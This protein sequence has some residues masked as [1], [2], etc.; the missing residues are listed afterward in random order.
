MA[1]P[2]TLNELFFTAIDRFRRNPVA[3]RVKRGG[4]W[5]SLS[6]DELLERVQALSLGLGEL[7]VRAGDRV[8]LLSE[9]RPEWAIADYACLTAR[10][11]DVPVYPTLPPKQIEYIL[12]DSGAVAL[13]VS[14]REQL[15]K[16]L[17][18]RANL[19]ALRHVIAFDER[20]E[21]E[22]VLPLEAVYA[23]GRAVPELAPAW[24]EA[25]LREA[26]DDLAT[27]IYTSGTTGEPKGVMLTHGNITTNVV[28]SL[29]VLALREGDECL[30]FLPLSHI[31]ERMAGHYLML[32][33]GTVISYASS[34]DAVS[35]EMQE[36][37]PTV[38]LSVPRLFEKIYARVLETAL[39]GS[40][41]KRS[42]FFWAKRVGEEWVEYRLT[43][44]QV[45][46]LLDM[47]YW[48]ARRLV[49]RKLHARVGS[50]LRFFVS[51]GAPLSADIARFFYAAG[52]PILEG[53]GLTETSPVIAVNRPERTR[54]G[55]VGPLISGV[56]VKIAPDGEILTRGPHVMKGYYRKPEATA[57]VIDAE[58]WFHT[59]DIGEL[60]ADGFLRI[61]DRKKD[62]IVTAGGKNIAPQP[63]E[64][65]AKMNKYVAN[66][67]MIGDKRRFP[68]ML[69]VPNFEKLVAWA[70]HRGL[71]FT[72]MAA[73][74]ALPETRA[75]IEREMQKAL[76]GLAHFEM[77]KKFLLLPRDFT[78]EA[79]ELTPKLSVRR[80]Q[81]E[82]NFA[83]EIEGL[84]EESVVEGAAAGV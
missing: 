52:L 75:K 45:P 74:V 82:K 63:I 61:T 15:D 68:A 8:G 19:P 3:L 7:G 33:S 32:R 1:P 17:E 12:R 14:T 55:T 58:G 66:A 26:P 47:Q 67:V 77:P 28:A 25:A 59:G 2:L 35:A 16:I 5:I 9:N 40:A 44:R 39:A 37:K 79:G 57:E 83:R 38:V 65:L 10:C 78:I 31:F 30:S 36:V 42:L 84:Y 13:L 64:N 70:E 4:R 54:L 11:T 49:F 62:L 81:V 41:I 46:G 22:G 18:I 29:E 6:Y 27:L 60:D 23:L 56:E 73:L 80:R 51:G 72:D 20:L 21:A 48:L 34:I 76:A 69:I 71:I 24:R 50:R 43:G 53:Y